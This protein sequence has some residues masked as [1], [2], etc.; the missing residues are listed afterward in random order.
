MTAEAISTI[1]EEQSD[2]LKLAILNAQI[3][4]DKLAS[5]VFILD[6]RNT[7]SAPTDFFVICSC[8]SQQQ[9]QAVAD[10]IFDEVADYKLKKPRIEGFE[11]GEWVL[12]D[13]FDIVVHVM[14]KETRDFYKIEKLWGDADFYT[15]DDEAEIHKTSYEEVLRIYP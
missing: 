8:D 2:S 4:Q 11:S 3:C 9:V 7:D 10:R 12:V 6:L 14:F 13:Y 1:S 5:D 15:V